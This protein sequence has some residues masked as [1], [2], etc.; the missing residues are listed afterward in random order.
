MGAGSGG[1]VI[2]RLCKME[3][4]GAPTCSCAERNMVGGG[5]G[6]GAK[7]GVAGVRQEGSSSWN[8]RWQST[9][10]GT[11]TTPRPL[12]NKTR[13]NA[14][15]SIAAQRGAGQHVTMFNK[16]SV[17]IAVFWGYAAAAASALRSFYAPHTGTPYWHH[18]VP[19]TATVAGPHHADVWGACGAGGLLRAT[20]RHKASGLS[21]NEPT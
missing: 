3:R 19:P 1:P 20:E 12:P 14:C 15:A 10:F 6:Q 18:H 9:V 8:A 11:R 13:L 21:T 16:D 4:L 2:V 5:G 17:G 7:L